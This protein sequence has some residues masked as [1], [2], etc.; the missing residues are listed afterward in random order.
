MHL[1][2]VLKSEVKQQYQL[3]VE[4]IK[5]NLFSKAY[6]VKPLTLTV[7]ASINPVYIF[8]R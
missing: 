1:F 5:A 2:I 3:I 8:I 4:C 7:R 6:P